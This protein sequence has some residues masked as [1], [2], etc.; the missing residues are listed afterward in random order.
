MSTFG[1]VL[2]VALV[3]GLAYV[4]YFAYLEYQAANRQDLVDLERQLS[5]AKK[6]CVDGPP[7]GTACAE[8]ARLTLEIANRGRR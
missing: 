6:A 4:V 3:V 2:L 5:T 7:A 1:R 8:A